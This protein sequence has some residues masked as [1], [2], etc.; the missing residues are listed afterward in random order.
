MQTTAGR[1]NASNVP[2]QSLPPIAS[3]QVQ[4]PASQQ[5]QQQ[6]SQSNQNNRLPVL[7]NQQPADNIYID[8]DSDEENP[9]QQYP[10]P[11]PQPPLSQPPPPSS[12][13]SDNRTKG[14]SKSHAKPNE[15]AELQKPSIPFGLKTEPIVK[16]PTR[17]IKSDILETYLQ[18]NN[19]QN[20]LNELEKLELFAE[21]KQI[22]TVYVLLIAG[23]V[24]TRKL[25][26][27]QYLISKYS[28]N[29]GL[30]KSLN[31]K[32]LASLIGLCEGQSSMDIV[33]DLYEKELPNKKDLKEYSKLFPLIVNGMK[34]IMNNKEV[35]LNDQQEKLRLYLIE[36]KNNKDKTFS[37]I[38]ECV[39][40]LTEV[41]PNITK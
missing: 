31:D 39:M 35:I 34:E 41:D 24:L 8:D 28:E 17:Q 22:T 9:N 19:Y 23:Y 10:Q 37:T 26:Q 12:T 36:N 30:D 2:Q 38:K 14:I 21:D 13:G 27:I 4:N 18:Q 6:S 16:R 5:Q 29:N 20:F 33:I 25:F 40:N 11:V 15:I 1:N 32:L 7:Q 3:Q